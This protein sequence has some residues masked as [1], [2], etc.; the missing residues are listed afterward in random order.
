[1]ADWRAEASRS[2]G[3]TRRLD[4]SE[5]LGIW[6]GMGDD[7]AREQQATDV[8]AEALFTYALPHK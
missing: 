4:L 6:I 8:R 3:S 5:R 1:M 7:M 2:Q